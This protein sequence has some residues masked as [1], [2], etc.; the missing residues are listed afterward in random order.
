MNFIAKFVRWK[1]K[2]KIIYCSYLIRFLLK[3]VIKIMLKIRTWPY[4][5]KKYIIK[6]LRNYE[7]L[8][9]IKKK[10]LITRIVKVKHS[11]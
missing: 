2:Y 6:N 3:K 11:K 8:R 4:N 7:R 5:K 9:F 10:F 1:L